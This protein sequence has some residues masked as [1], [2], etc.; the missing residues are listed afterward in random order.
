MLKFNNFF[1][2]NLI[3]LLVEEDRRDQVSQEACEAPKFSVCFSDLAEFLGLKDEVMHKLAQFDDED[4]SVTSVLASG[5]ARQDF[6]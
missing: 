6:S 5:H 1:K 2:Q 4:E 3:K